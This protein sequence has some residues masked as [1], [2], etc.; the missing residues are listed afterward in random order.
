MVYSQTDK[1]GEKFFIQQ[2]SRVCDNVAFFWV[3]VP[4]FFVYK[5]LDAGYSM[6]DSEKVKI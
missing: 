1:L 6:L 5:M 3:I 2:L 4:K